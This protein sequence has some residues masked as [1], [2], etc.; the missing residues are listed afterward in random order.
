MYILA[1]LLIFLS[2]LADLITLLL[3]LGKICVQNSAETNGS[4]FSWKSTYLISRNP[5]LFSFL[6]FSPFMTLVVA[7]F[8]PSVTFFLDL[9]NVCSATSW[10]FILL[11]VSNPGLFYCLDNVFLINCLRCWSFIDPIY[12]GIPIKEVI[13]CTVDWGY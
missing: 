5:G 1:F 4:H 6:S 11:V 10:L 2:S 9:I 7:D 8:C 12:I 3:D 13:T